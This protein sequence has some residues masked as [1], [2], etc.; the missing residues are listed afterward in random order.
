MTQTAMT[1]Y[2]PSNLAEIR[3]MGEMLARSGYFND[4]KHMS[5][6]VAKMLAGIELGFSPMAAMTGIYFV[7][8]RLTLGS[9]M[10][11]QAVK[12]SGKYDYRV[13]ELTDRLCRID[14]LQG[15]DL[16]GTSEF[17]M[18]DARRAD[19][20]K[21]DG[22]WEKWP[23]N[24]LFARAL[25]NGVRF[26]CP[27]A[28]STGPTYTPEELGAEVDEDGNF[29]D[30]P[31]QEY[32][33]SPANR[34]G[35]VEQVAAQFGLDQDKARQGLEAREREGVINAYMSDEEV[36]H[37]LVE[38]AARPNGQQKQETE[39]DVVEGEVTGEKP[40]DETSTNDAPENGRPATPKGKTR[41]TGKAAGDSGEPKEKE[42]IPWHKRIELIQRIITA[43]HA[44]VPKHALNLLNKLEKDGKA[45]PRWTD[46]AAFVA[47]EVYRRTDDGGDSE[48]ET[49]DTPAGPAEWVMDARKTAFIERWGKESINERDL[50]DA[51]QVGSWLEVT[52]SEAEADAAVVIYI[53]KMTGDGGHD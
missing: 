41:Q 7:K 52:R 8:G 46:E 12:R 44:T 39:P 29:I 53:E 1:V 15:D 9:N 45:D 19:L 50:L 10:L 38:R 14:F 6:A 3:D 34:P 31:A 33:G 43:G 24:M 2:Q 28:L 11:A 51:M 37:I 25:S 21:D 13:R 26:Y 23:R 42:P 22:A 30:M 49:D 36:H 20:I 5:Q 48:T 27:D 40:A 17:T 35:L 32:L 47:V 18:D 4:V 16:L